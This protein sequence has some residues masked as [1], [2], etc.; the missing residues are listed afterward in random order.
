MKPSGKES[1]L[2]QLV[3]ANGEVVSAY[4][5]NSDKAVKPGSKLQNVNIVPKQSSNGQYNLIS[6]YQIAA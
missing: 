4:I 3:N 2:L 5:K 1:Q 6:G